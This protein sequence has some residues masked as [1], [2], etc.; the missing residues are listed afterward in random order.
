M[1]TLF[2]AQMQRTNFERFGENEQ[3]DYLRE[4]SENMPYAATTSCKIERL[5][6]TIEATELNSRN[7]SC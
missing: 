1:R 5:S 6:C 4:N 2:L 3:S 7:T